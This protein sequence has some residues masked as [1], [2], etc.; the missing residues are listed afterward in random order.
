[1][2]GRFHGHRGGCDH[3]DG[4]FAVFTTRIERSDRLTAQGHAERL[5]SEDAERRQ[6]EQAT[7]ITWWTRRPGIGETVDRTAYGGRPDDERNPD[8]EVFEDVDLHILN[9]S[10]SAIYACVV[11]AA[12]HRNQVTG[13][14][15]AG[16]VP[17]GKQIYAERIFCGDSPTGASRAAAAISAGGAVEYV[18]FAD[19]NQHIWRR[20]M[21]G[22]LVEVDKSPEVSDQY[23]W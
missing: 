9:A 10:D 22:R 23:C 15:W 19:S 12:Q 1:M 7:K 14:R 16:I 2:G 20:F 21:D 17:P 4:S 8:D 11:R 13:T 6:R 5:Y 18:E 3:L